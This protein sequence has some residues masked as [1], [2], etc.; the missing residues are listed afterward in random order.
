MSRPACSVEQCER[1]PRARGMCKLHWTRWW[2]YGDPNVVLVAGVD[3]RVKATCAVDGCDRT[4]VSRSFCQK[5]LWRLQK[6]GDPL[7]F[8]PP[9]ERGIKGEAPTSST[10]HR[11]LGRNRGPARSY[12]C[13]DCAGQARE[14]SYDG[15][16]ANEI[17]AATGPYSL[18]LDHYEPRCVPCHRRYDASWQ[19]R[20]RTSL[21]QFT[22]KE[23]ADV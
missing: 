18:N 10:I 8:T 16:D 6:H 3:F 5:H 7:A 12:S 1:A 15:K 11:R 17:P 4:G 21:G 23:A 22:P 9:E 13:V 14:W 19:K 20:G 2:K